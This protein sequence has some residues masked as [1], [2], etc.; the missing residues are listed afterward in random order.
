MSWKP[1]LTLQPRVSS[2]SF[3][4][5]YHSSNYLFKNHI[6]TMMAS[7]VLNEYLCF[8][9][10]VTHSS[11]WTRWTPISLPTL[12]NGIQKKVKKCSK[13]HR[14]CCFVMTLM[15]NWP[16]F[17]LSLD[18]R[19]YLCHQ[20]VPEENIIFIFIW[21]TPNIVMNYTHQSIVILP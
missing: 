7:L 6:E 8:S 12:R 13:R 16:A 1:R 19:D 15:S 10:L 3:Q 5:F 9:S 17:L 20:L 4:W 18:I 21:C 2:V 11:R 14:R